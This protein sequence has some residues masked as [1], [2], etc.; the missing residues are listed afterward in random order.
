MSKWKEALEELL[1]TKRLEH[2]HR[3]L[4]FGANKSSI[5][6]NQYLR[7]RGFCPEGFI[8]N[9]E[10][11]QGSVI[12]GM[13][14]VSPEAALS[15]Y[16]SHARILIASEYHKQM[17]EQLQQMGY[18]KEREVFV[19]D[20]IY[21]F[22]DLSEKAMKGYL[23][24]A[25]LGK[26]VYQRLIREYG[27]S[28]A[29]DTV[30][31]ECPYAGTGDAYLIG[32]LLR[33]YMERHSISSYVITVVS[34]SCEKII[35]MFGFDHVV[36][37]RQEESDGLVAFLR[38]MRAHIPHLILNDNYQTRIMHRRLRGYKGIDFR[39]MFQYAV[40]R[41]EEPVQLS[42]SE[43]PCEEEKL[44]RIIEEQ[45]MIEGRT[46]ILSPYANTIANLPDTIWEQIVLKYQKK[47]YV[48]FTNSAGANEPAIR[49]TKPVFLP[50]DQMVPLL[51][52]GGTFIGMRSGL[53]DIIAAAKCKKI[54]LYPSGCIFGSCTTYQYFSLN[55][56]GLC[57][58][59]VELEF[60]PGREEEIV[61]KVLCC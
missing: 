50:Y 22:Y 3:I 56:M 58:D 13:K 52:W 1:R 41:L 23:S 11:K 24:A 45:G 49:G 61:G 59:A 2:E 9:S 15:V 33:V 37:L 42:R 28:K 43:K 48:V 32:A 18:E 51:E 5:E 38:M 44:C 14:V 46:V 36:T 20:T 17:C 29:L 4:F 25:E 10:K 8:D 57:E 27:A 7:E 54:I 6:M 40:F 31:F 16:D 60:E 55:A 47:G 34:K 26:E 21:S 12:E 35:R 19:T 39:H 53:C 30:L